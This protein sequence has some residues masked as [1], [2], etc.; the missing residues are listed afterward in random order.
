[1]ARDH[2]NNAAD[3]PQ[4]AFTF[5]DSIIGTLVNGAAKISLH[6]IINADAFTG[7]ASANENRIINWVING[8]NTT[9]G[10]LCVDN[11]TSAG[12]PKLRLGARS[13]TTDSFQAVNGA[14]NLSA[15]TV[16]VVGGVLDISGDAIRVYLDGTEDGSGSVTFGAS[17]YTQGTVTA[18]NPD[19]IGGTSAVQNYVD[20]L[21]AEVAIWTSDIGAT[22]F[23]AL[24]KRF[25]PR[26]VDF[27]NLV[28]YCPLW[29]RANP[30]PELINN[31]HVTIG[32]YD[33]YLPHPAVIRRGSTRLSDAAVAAVTARRHGDWITVPFVN[34]GHWT[35]A[36]V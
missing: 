5:G 12:N 28:I 27:E 4:Y 14:T 6:A 20:G 9:G 21:L 32:T 13:Q 26:S 34:Q 30:E 11:F 16:Y 36:R 31:K 33:Q 2:E 35:G 18:G 7:L 29:G 22:G 8:T 15:G 25:D 19:S 3:D 10:A 17:S 1:M 23:A 24:G